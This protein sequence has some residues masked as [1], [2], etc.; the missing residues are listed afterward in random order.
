MV[1]PV[2]WRRNP[3]AR[4]CEHL[5]YN[6]TIQMCRTNNRIYERNDEES[7]AEF[8]RND[9]SVNFISC[10]AVY[11]YLEFVH[12]CK[13]NEIPML[14]N[15]HWSK[16]WRVLSTIPWRTLVKMEN[17]VE[18]WRPWRNSETVVKFRDRGEIWRP[19]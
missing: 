7:R 10:I 12:I 14:S 19:W 15:G 18:N 1:R 13:K 5:R 8:I 9:I 17:R 11:V 2:D 4:W 3:K 6:P 16:I